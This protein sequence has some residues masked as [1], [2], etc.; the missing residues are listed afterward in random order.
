M[1]IDMDNITKSKLQKKAGK[2]LVIF[3]IVMLILTAVSRISASLTV[4]LVTTARVNKASLSY[5][6]EGEGRI[7]A[8]N[9]I[10]LDLVTG[11]EISKVYVKR[12]Q[13]VQNGNPLFCY[14]MERLEA[15][16][17]KARQEY[18]ASKGVYEKLVLTESLRTEQE[19]TS[20]EKKSI[21]RANED[22]KEAQEQLKVAKSDYKDKI[23]EIK[24]QLSETQKQE[25][26]LALQ[27]YEIGR[28]HV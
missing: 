17:D 1:V 11:L 16:I 23:S 19:D 25:Y 8:A 5:K 3:L 21:T 20:K 13:S 22:Y 6:I 2:Y 24:K 10:Y 4:P 27:E 15:Q 28:A 7:D 14:N 18:K 26:E 12:G 9:A